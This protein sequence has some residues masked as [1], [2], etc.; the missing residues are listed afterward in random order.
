MTLDMAVN[1]TDAMFK[2]T[3]IVV[4]PVILITFI[5]GLLIS[6]FQAATQINEMTLTF[7]PKIVATAIGLIIFGSWMTVK[8]VDYTRGLFE[9][10]LTITR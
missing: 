9:T 8:L 7:V 6:I 3:I 5:V 2:T 1:L 4:A 10:I